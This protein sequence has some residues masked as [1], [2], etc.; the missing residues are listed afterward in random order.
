LRRILHRGRLVGVSVGVGTEVAVGVGVPVGV[1]VGVVV[2]VAVTE[3]VGV[4]VLV[5]LG[6][7]VALGDLV[8]LGVTVGPAVGGVAGRLTLPARRVC[9]GPIPDPSATASSPVRRGFV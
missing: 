7:S 6:D 3:E 1:T 9:V 2:Q 4:W 8:T 5:A